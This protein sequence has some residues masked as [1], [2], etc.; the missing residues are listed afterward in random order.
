MKR[1]NEPRTEELNIM[2][3]IKEQHHQKVTKL[4]NILNILSQFLNKKE[5]LNTSIKQ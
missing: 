2:P 5:K 1:M 3:S 4:S